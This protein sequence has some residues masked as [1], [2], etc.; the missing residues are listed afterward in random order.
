MWLR[1]GTFPSFKGDTDAL[2]FKTQEYFG[3]G[4]SSEREIIIK[5]DLYRVLYDNNLTEKLHF[6][7]LGDLK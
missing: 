1:K 6:K 5:P 4:F 7:V 3:S 2:I